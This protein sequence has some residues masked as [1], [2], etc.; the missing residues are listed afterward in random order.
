MDNI[1]SAAVGKGDADGTPTDGLVVGLD[2]GIA[3]ITS[4]TMPSIDE[5]NVPC[6]W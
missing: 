1:A 6:C 5:R 2:V 4:A 3:G